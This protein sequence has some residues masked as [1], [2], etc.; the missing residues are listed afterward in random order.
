MSTSAIQAK[1]EKNGFSY[2][3]P[4]LFSKELRSRALTLAKDYARISNDN[5]NSMISKEKEIYMSSESSF[6]SVRNLSKLFKQKISDKTVIYR[7]HDSIERGLFIDIINPD[8][9]LPSL[10]EELLQST[11]YQEIKNAS[12]IHGHDIEFHIYY[13]KSCL[14]PRSWHI[15]GPSLKIFTYLTDVEKKHGPYAYQLNSQSFYDYEYNNLGM[16]PSNL[17][18]LKSNVTQK[19]LDLGKVISPIG[20]EGTSFISNQAGIHRGMDQQNGEERVVLVTQF[21]KA[22]L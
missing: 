15:D 3:D 14:K 17:K 8:I 12:L 22:K 1:L 16:K 6:S 11:A 13:T 20:S 19:Y 9:H 21:I 4:P 10:K 5:S 18:D 2:I 7:R